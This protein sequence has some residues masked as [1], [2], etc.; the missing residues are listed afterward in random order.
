ML[1]WPELP[2]GKVIFFSAKIWIVL[3][4]LFWRFRVDREPLSWS[5]ARHG[6][7][8]LATATGLMISLVIFCAYA[9]TTRLG[10]L[11]TA[12]VAERAAKTGLNQ[13]GLYVGGALYWITVNSLMEEFVWRWFVFRKC[14]ALM[15][16]RIA[17]AA[18]ALAFTAHHVIALAAQFHWQIT[19]LGSIG[20]F[21][22]GVVWN[23]LY[24]RYRSIWPGYVSHAIADVAIFVI[25]YRLIFVTVAPPDDNAPAGL[26]LMDQVIAAFR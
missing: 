14:E 11:D 25:G 2:I 12:L 21:I 26:L 16:G 5:P 22:G 19:V 1:W 6:G 24:Q 8:G 9:V 10:L 17:V 20:V 23:L 18:G 7:F 15:G 3:L 13:L 4:P